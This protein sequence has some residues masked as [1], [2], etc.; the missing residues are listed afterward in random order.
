MT[1][2]ATQWLTVNEVLKEVR[3]SLSTIAV[4]CS[5]GKGPKLYRRMSGKPSASSVLTSSL[6][7]IDGAGMRRP[8]P[9]IRMLRRQERPGKVAPLKY[10]EPVYAAKLNAERVERTAAPR[11]VMSSYRA[12]KLGNRVMAPSGP[13]DSS[14]GTRR[15]LQTSSSLY[16]SSAAR[17]SRSVFV[18]HFESGCRD[19]LHHP[20]EFGPVRGLLRVEEFYSDRPE[21]HSSA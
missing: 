16:R 12:R 15:P 4:W 7:R 14:R 10:E 9:T 3:C 13:G 1:T 21:M 17:R 20:S 8:A 6:A 19:Q 2:R 5:D 18:E 11:Q